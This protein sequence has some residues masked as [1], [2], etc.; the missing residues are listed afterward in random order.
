MLSFSEYPYLFFLLMAVA[1]IPLLFPLFVRKGRQLQV[2]RYFMWLML[3]CF[4]YSFS[5]FLELTLPAVGSKILMIK[6]QYL[7]AVFFAPL[8]IMF[9]LAY[10]EKRDRIFKQSIFLLLFLPLINLVLVWT[11]D[12]HQLFYT[13]FEI[14]HNGNFQLIQTGKGYFYW[15]HQGYTLILLFLSLALLVQRIREIP[16]SDSRQVLMVILGLCSPLLLY[17]WYLSG[18]IP[19]L[20]DPIPFGFLGTSIF[21]YLGL[22]KFNLFTIVPIAYRTLFNNMQEG[23]LVLDKNGRLV[24]LNLSAAKLIGISSIQEQRAMREIETNWPEILE[25]ISGENGYQISECKRRNEG[26]THWYLLTKSLVKDENQKLAGS[27]ILIREITQEKNFQIEIERSRE[28][29]EDAN[30]AKSEFLANMSHEIRT[31]L[32][33]VIGFTEL[34]TKTRLNE[35]QQRYAQTALNSANTLLGLIN[36]VLDLAKIESGKADFHKESIVLPELLENILDVLSFQAHQKGLELVLEVKPNVPEKIE[37]DELKLRQVLLNLLNNA[38]KFTESG[39]VILR[40]E[41]KAGTGSSDSGHVRFAVVDSG[42]GIPNEKQELIF[43]AFSQADSSTTKKFGGTGLGLTICNKLLKLMESKIQLESKEGSGSCFYFD[44]P[45]TY[46]KRSTKRIKGISQVLILDGNEISGKAIEGYCMGFALKTLFVTSVN[47]AFDLL[48]SDRSISVVL[49]NHAM[50]GKNS[51]SAM[52]Q[53]MQI[54][55][56]Q[57]KKV[58]FVALTGSNDKEETIK[59]YEKI[60]CNFTLDKPVTPGKLKA[61]FSRIQKGVQPAHLPPHPSDDTREAIQPEFTVLLAEDNAVNRMLVKIYIQKLSPNARILEAE[62]GKMALDLLLQ[63]VPDMVITDIH[64]PQMNGNELLLAIRA[65]PNGNDIPVI[66]FTANAM[67]SENSHGL[68]VAGFDAYL[69]KPVKQEKFR[70]IVSPWFPAGN[71][72]KK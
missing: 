22:K 54:A 52:E 51:L 18:D 72:E 23:V 61:L 58:D 1:I 65:L 60:G 46:S 19:Y 4:I 45:A 59:S 16:P 26:Y 3:A 32:N 50:L 21:F 24:T 7:G 30:R 63:E 41:W 37:T 49:L 20:L 57:K 29:A 40:V 68:S 28:A 31:P 67:S 13:Y 38:V 33:G 34:L 12:W 14:G 35:Q 10:T 42:I 25:L 11:N 2:F 53:M 62:D 5:Y 64:M 9:T 69:T 27:L 66:G 71:T 56:K 70:E 47:D 39:E 55:R 48:K 8:V 43:E 17:I 15:V 44:L 36:D 6:A